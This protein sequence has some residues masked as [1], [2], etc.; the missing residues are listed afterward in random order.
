MNSFARC[1]RWIGP[2]ET[3]IAVRQVNNEKMRLLLDAVDKD[4]GLTKISLGMSRFG[5]FTAAVRR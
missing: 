5:R 2:H 1:C 3:T 4:Y